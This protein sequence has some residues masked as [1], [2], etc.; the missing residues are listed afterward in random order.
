MTSSP[1]DRDEL[2]TP[3][4]RVMLTALGNFHRALA[5]LDEGGKPNPESHEVASSVYDQQI[6]AARVML[7]V[8][9]DLKDSMA[10]SDQYGFAD[11]LRDINAAIAAAEAAGITDVPKCSSCNGLGADPKTGETCDA[12]MGGG[13]KVEG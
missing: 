2:E 13:D 11:E 5:H 3:A 8:L 7:A 9:R 1:T 6:E 4:T 12:C 10:Y